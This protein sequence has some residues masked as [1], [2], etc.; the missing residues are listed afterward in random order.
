MSSSDSPDEKGK[1]DNDSLIEKDKD[2]SIH[3]AST[4][5]AISSDEGEIIENSGNDREDSLNAHKN[6]T[7]PEDSVV[8]LLG[9]DNYEVY[10]KI[11][12]ASKLVTD[13]GFDNELVGNFK[14]KLI[15]VDAL[16]FMTF[17][18][19]DLLIQVEKL[20]IRIKFK[21]KWME[22]KVSNLSISI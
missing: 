21:Q 15:D 19:V 10:A 22:W 18:N 3:N 17:A 12:Y 5:G 6:V 13:W 9:D 4:S 2:R 20:G 11:D 14:D 16:K 8:V 1:S 7:I